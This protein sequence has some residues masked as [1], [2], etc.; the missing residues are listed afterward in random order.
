MSYW[1]QVGAIYW[2]PQ[3]MQAT[4]VSTR[5]KLRYRVGSKLPIDYR[6]YSSTKER[7]AITIQLI[8]IQFELLLICSI[9]WCKVS[10]QTLLIMIINHYDHTQMY[11]WWVSSAL[12]HLSSTTVHCTGFTELDAEKGSS[13]SS[14]SMMEVEK[15]SRCW[16]Q[17]K[18]S[19]LQ[20]W[21]I[22]QSLQDSSRR[23]WWGF[24]WC[25]RIWPLRTYIAPIGCTLAHII[26]HQ[27]LSI[28]QNNQ[29]ITPCHNEF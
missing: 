20:N 15:R 13:T 19:L 10:E 18:Y 27:T 28:R 5:R 11:F 3:E 29:A 12:F 1:N 21:G 2:L 26:M 24:W 4:W 22:H 6:A 9:L 14:L 8:H 7:N 17:N 25:H 23:N 16:N